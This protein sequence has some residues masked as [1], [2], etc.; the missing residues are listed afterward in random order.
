MVSNL[1]EKAIES[2]KNNPLEKLSEGQSLL[3][4]NA[5]LACYE[6]LECMDAI[7]DTTYYRQSLKVKTKAVMEELEKQSMAIGD[8]LGI[9]NE[10]L[11]N[12][13]LHKKQLIQKIAKIRPEEK[14]GV[15][16]LLEAYLSAPSLTLHR[17]GIKIID[18]DK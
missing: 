15:N 13:M 10:A 12:L 2:I 7:Q 17:L 9:D 18:R 16:A 11:S 1:R 8:V 4:L 6:H 14:S 3:V 5:I